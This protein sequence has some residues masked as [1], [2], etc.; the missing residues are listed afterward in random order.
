MEKRDL[1]IVGGGVVGCGVYYEASISPDVRSCLLVEKYPAV[2]QVNSNVLANAETLHKGIETNFALESALRMK[3]YAEYLTEYLDVYGEGM[4]V[5]LPSMVIGVTPAERV[6]LEDRYKLLKPH[7]PELELVGWKKIASVEPLVTEGRS[8]KELENLVALYDEVG[9]AVDYE[10]LAQSFVRN[11]EAEAKKRGKNFSA[12]FRVKTLDIRAENGHYCVETDCGPF[13][14]DVVDVCAGPY[15]MSF[16]HRMGHPDALAYGILP[17]AGSFF[18]TRKKVLNGKVYTYQFPKI[19]L[20]A[21][22]GD[23]AVYNEHQ[24]RFGPTASLWPFFEQGHLLS[25]IDFMRMGFVNPRDY[26]LS[27]GAIM[28]DKDFRAF[29]LRNMAYSMPYVGRHYFHKWAVQ[30]IVPTLQEE[31]L[32]FGWGMGGI[33]PQLVDLKARKVQMGL[34]KFVGNGIIYNV[35]PSPGAS[36][37]RGNAREDLRVIGEFLRTKRGS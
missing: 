8:G 17:V 30:K 37:C 3:G 25:A 7:F 21:P 28:L 5:H 34:G 20:A 6:A 16:A 19:P 23:R 15:S 36:S 11:A 35:T 33:R 29:E 31:D 22:H 10:K 9:T 12:L 14:G 18:Y 1:V 24:T 32:H 26:A 27:V 4:Y 2:A 13:Y